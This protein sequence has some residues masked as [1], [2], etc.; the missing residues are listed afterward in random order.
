MKYWFCWQGRVTPSQIDFTVFARNI[1]CPRVRPYKCRHFFYDYTSPLK[2]W[3][4]LFP[5]ASSARKFGMISFFKHSTVGWVIFL[6][7]AV[8]TSRFQTPTS[9]GSASSGAPR[10]PCG[11]KHQTKGHCCW[12]D[13]Y[14]ILLELQCLE[15]L[16]TCSCMPD[17]ISL[18]KSSCDVKV[19]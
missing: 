8:E 13:L 1:Y 18:I 7:R 12:F 15:S 10:F 17:W 2:I 5:R 11:L 4:S 3:A 19:I 16:H 9:P 14:C 6:S